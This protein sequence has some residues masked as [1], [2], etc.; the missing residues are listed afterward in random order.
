M[1]KRRRSLYYIVCRGRGKGT[2]PPRVL[3]LLYVIVFPAQVSTSVYPVSCM[4]G[5]GRSVRLR[6]QVRPMDVFTDVSDPI[7]GQ[8]HK[9]CA[10]STRLL[11][12]HIS[13]TAWLI[14]ECEREPALQEPRHL[15]VLAE[16]NCRRGTSPSYQPCR[17]ADMDQQ[18]SGHRAHLVVYQKPIRRCRPWLA[19]R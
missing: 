12:I 18:A 19:V 15:R 16:G 6:H 1:I 4:F 5:A 11:T 14:R 2:P 9:M 10:M 8:T 17:D 13:V 3:L 7:V